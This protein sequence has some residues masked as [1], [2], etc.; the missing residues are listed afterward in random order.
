MA[1][2]L[3]WFRRDLRLE[4]NTALQAACEAEGEV[5]PVYIIDPGHKDWAHSSAARLS[6]RLGCLKEL[7][8]NIRDNGGELLVRR[9]NQTKVFSDL[10]ENI[11]PEA[12]YWNRAYEPY[13]IKRDRSVRDLLEQRGVVVNTFKDLVFFEKE[14][15]LTKQDTPYKVFTPYSRRWKARQKPAVS[16]KAVS[17]GETSLRAGELPGVEE[18]GLEPCLD[19]QNIWSPGRKAKNIL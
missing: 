16:E 7:R 8:E 11:K 15:I 13:E 12:V 3:F 1:D 19:E 9:G 4:D 5:H 2:V 6:F 18:L 14:E 17:F 10:A